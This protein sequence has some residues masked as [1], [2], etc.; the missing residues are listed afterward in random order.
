MTAWTSMTSGIRLTGISGP[1]TLTVRAAVL[2]APDPSGPAAALESMDGAVLRLFA[3]DTLAIAR[4]VGAGSDQVASAA[5]V[6][7]VGWSAAPARTA[8]ARI[9]AAAQDTAAVLASQSRALERTAEVI[10]RAVADARLDCDLAVAEINSVDRHSWTDLAGAAIGV[11]QLGDGLQVAS[12]LRGLFRSLNARIASVDAALASLQSALA[13][14]PAEG[15]DALRA[16]TD[17]LLPPDPVLNPAHRTDEQNRSALALDL[18]SGIPSRMRFAMSILQTLRRAS[19]RGGSASL[20]VYDS[21]AYQGQGR[22][23]IVVGDLTTATNVAVVVPGISNSPADMDGG[24]DL[25]GDLR[26]EANRQDPSG[27][28]A[29]VAWY[30]YDIPL[31]WAKD[32]G[33]RPPVDVL[34]TVA[35]GSAANASS[36]APVLA[37]DLARIRAMSQSSVRT[38]LIGFSMGST[39]VSEA[40]RYALPVDSL[41]LLGSPGAGWDTRSA[42]GYRTVAASDVYVLSYDQDPVTLAVTDDLARKELGLSDPYGPDPAAAS[43]GAQH[44]DAVTNVPILTGSGLVASLGR[45]LGDPRH[46]SMKNYMQGGALAAEGSIVVGH[47]SQVPTKPGRGAR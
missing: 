28:T 2:G 14:D 32:P 29:V 46:H 23:A 33:S 8:L 7:A 22:A 39:T 35:V 31:S 18:R 34:D 45:I 15:P 11:P 30:G 13:R 12:I 40:A 20:V 38:T 36:G 9:T 47:R 26:D 3:Q 25:A 27:R 37:A 17:A 44:I 16:G 24:I 5:P 6:L 43:F 1:G 42:G 41:V 10:D 21:R 19:D 4:A